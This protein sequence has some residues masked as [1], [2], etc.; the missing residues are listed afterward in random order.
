MKRK[1]WKM[2]GIGND[3]IYFDCT[4]EDLPDP[5]RLAVRLSDRHFSVGG[6]GIILV[7]GS[8]IA[9]GKMRMFN[10]DGSEGK[11][12]GNG[13]RCVGKFLY[14]VLGIRKEVLTVET[15]SGVKE[16][17]LKTENGKVVSVTVGM[18]RAVLTPSEIPVLLGKDR[19]VGVPL[20][21]EGK[22]YRV[23]CVSMGNP[24]CVVFGGDPYE[25][26]LEKI[27][28]L[29]E[30]HPAFPERVNTEFVQPLAPNE[31]RMRVFER[32]SGETWACGTGACA[33]AVAAV[34]GGYS[35]EG[36]EVTVHLR[37]GDLKIVYAGGEVSMTGPAEF[38]F[39]GE[40][41]IGEE[42]D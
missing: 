18:G 28:P 31:L 9:D 37:G 27:G 6:D 1:F 42:K 5:A 4:K 11:M 19:A 39:T 38:A 13:I 3:Y 21:V 22:T 25:L 16:L 33:A 35:E 10:A 15:L 29:F 41:E 17:R 34:L 36:A 14:E 2:H 30:R 26:D 40:A 7:C 8:E 23:T 20:E 32:G 12:C 24:H